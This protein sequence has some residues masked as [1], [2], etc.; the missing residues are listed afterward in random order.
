MSLKNILSSLQDER[1]QLGKIVASLHAVSGGST[2]PPP[3]A[4]QVP[5]VEHYTLFR[6][7]IQHEDSLINNRLL[8]NINIQGFLFATFGLSVQKLYESSSPVGTAVPVTT[9]VALAPILLHALIVVLPLF[10]IGVSTLSLVTVRAAEAAIQNLRAKWQRLL[11]KNPGLDELL[12]GIIG[13]GLESSHKGGLRA[14]FLVPVVF[15]A[16]WLLLFAASVY[17][18]HAASASGRPVW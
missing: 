7:Y 17:H 8:W 9:T 18:L 2:A 4:S 13:G 3:P 15:I 6:A 11:A 14:P 1:E 12:P 10:G 5:T 16:A